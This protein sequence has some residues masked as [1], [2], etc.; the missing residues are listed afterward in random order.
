VRF[1]ER[2]TSDFTGVTFDTQ[3]DSINTNGNFGAEPEFFCASGNTQTQVPLRI[4]LLR[5]DL[6]AI[7][8]GAT[9]VSASLELWTG[10]DPLDAQDGAVAQL[11]AVLE[12]WTE[13]N[14]M[15]GAAGAAN[16]NQRKQGVS[17]ATPGA[18][19]PSSAN[20]TVVAELTAT[21]Q[22]SPYAV[23]L[24]TVLVQ[25]W[26]DLPLTNFGLACSILVASGDSDVDFKASESDQLDRRPELTITYRAP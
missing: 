24:P 6:S 20:A 9:V 16:F 19:P 26:V 21:E 3:L 8:A 2:P 23:A 18:R 10:N 25:T 1:G 13:G 4:G 5:F 11:R 12:E 22:F 15:D 17:W 14:A 7:P